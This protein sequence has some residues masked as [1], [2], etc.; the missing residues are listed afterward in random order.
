MSMIPSPKPYQNAS[1]YPKFDH[2]NN[3]CIFTAWY[4]ILVKIMLHPQISNPFQ[5]ITSC[6]VMYWN[7]QKSKILYQSPKLI[8]F[9]FFMF[10]TWVK[11]WFATCMQPSYYHDV[12]IE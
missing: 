8:N 1:F 12:S 4:A 11:N 9:L 2:G 7:H 3:L 10:S 6:L 5:L